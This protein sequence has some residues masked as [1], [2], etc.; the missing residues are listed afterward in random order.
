[1]LIRKKS[2]RLDISS[3]LG[4][5]EVRVAAHCGLPHWIERVL[6]GVLGN[7]IVV[8]DDAE[9]HQRVHCYGAEIGSHG[10]VDDAELHKATE[11]SAMS[12]ILHS[13]LV[14]PLAAEAQ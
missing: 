3:S 2:G 9:Q 8:V 10:V 1:M 5:S 7:A 4:T 11:R 6:I 13:T 12:P 14:F